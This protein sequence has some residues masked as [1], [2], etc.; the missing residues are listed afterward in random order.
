[1]VL[2]GGLVLSA[3]AASAGQVWLLVPCA[4]TLGCAY[5]MCLVAGL[6]EVQRLAAGDALA[7]VV[8]AYY[9]L[10]YLGFAAPSLLALATHLASYTVL[11]AIAGLLALVTAAHVSHR[12]TQHPRPHRS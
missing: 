1:V 10:S 11:L 3:V 6:L 12:S 8:A 4:I 2:A 7:G 9:A 5:G